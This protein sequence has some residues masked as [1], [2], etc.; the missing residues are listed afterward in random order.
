MD[1][2]LVQ[3][4]VIDL[5]AARAGS[6]AAVARITARAMAGQLDFVQ[7]LRSRVATLAG[8]ST[9]VFAEVVRQ[10]T[11]TPGAAELVSAVQSAGG[12]VAAVSGGFHEVLDPIAAQLGVDRWSANR[13]AVDEQ[14]R[15]TGALAGPVVDAAA[16]SRAL[17]RWAGEFGV[18]LRCTV[19]VGDGAND[20]EMMAVA[21][22]SVAFQA[23]ASVRA[24]AHL[25]LD[26]R[27]L[28]E[29]LPLLG[30]R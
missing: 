20:L 14:G 24:A 22:L 28:A 30:L 23:K 21:G 15:L 16:K 7:S 3:D 27:D 6:G 11:V 10:V 17:Q 8:V 25:V 9:T 5:L 29:L 13:L 1:S 18:P 4:E 19:A 26:R 12:R 2:T